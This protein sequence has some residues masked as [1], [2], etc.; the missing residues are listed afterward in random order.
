MCYRGVLSDFPS[1]HRFDK[2]QQIRSQ[3]C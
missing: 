2:I 3:F 1:I